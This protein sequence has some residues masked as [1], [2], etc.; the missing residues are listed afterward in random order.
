[1]SRLA[2]APLLLALVACQAPP[3]RW[4]VRQL[5]QEPLAPIEHVNAVA[6]MPGQVWASLQGLT[7]G[8]D[9]WRRALGC[10]DDAGLTW[11]QVPAR[12]LG[13]VICLAAG[14]G[15]LLAGNADG[16]WISRDGGETFRAIDPR[17]PEGTIPQLAAVAAGD[18]ARL[19]SV[20]QEG[21]LT[22]SVDGGVSWS[23]LPDCAGSPAALLP[24]AGRVLLLNEVGLFAWSEGQGDWTR[25][26]PHGSPA[27]GGLAA[28]TDGRLIV[29]TTRPRG[30][31]D[32]IALSRDSGQ[33]WTLLA[34]IRS[35]VDVELDPRDPATLY[36]LTSS[37]DASLLVS[38]DRGE[39]W[40]PLSGDLGPDH[41]LGVWT[42]S[43]LWVLPTP[44]G[45]TSLLVTSR[46]DRR[47][48][49]LADAG[50]V[51]R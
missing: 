14:P 41:G 45:R 16:L 27:P 3:P 19:F 8:G 31:A 22:A 48:L 23:W 26:S 29:A 15:V 18:P 9:R 25:L 13:D 12:G 24:V 2:L 17:L 44:E 34:G 50:R 10:S 35:V 49:F 37:S 6:V 20:T 4:E 28:S 42:G 33:T 32:R 39:S 47:A 1:M 5:G 7:P 30:D 51:P 11:R 38:R 36:A 21:R 46:L 40:S 43:E